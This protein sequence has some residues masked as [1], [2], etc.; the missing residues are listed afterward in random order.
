MNDTY[1]P[2]RQMGEPEEQQNPCAKKGCG[3]LLA[4]HGSWALQHAYVMPSNPTTAPPT[5]APRPCA[6]KGCGRLLAEHGSW[7]LQHAY[8]MPSHGGPTP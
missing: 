1:G 8:V 3:R 6:K 4:E 7:A 5:T 2:I